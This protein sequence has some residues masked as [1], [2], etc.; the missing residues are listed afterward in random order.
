M[1]VLARRSV[2]ASLNLYVDDGSSIVPSPERTFTAGIGNRTTVRDRQGRFVNA[3][4]GR[5]YIKPRR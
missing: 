2:L 4:Y 3:A 5:T 1:L